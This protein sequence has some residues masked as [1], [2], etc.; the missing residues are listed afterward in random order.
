MI[1]NLDVLLTNGAVTSTTKFVLNALDENNEARLEPNQN[2]KEN[3]Y[4]DYFSW[5]MYFIWNKIK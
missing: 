2:T 4:D 3:F 5:M 1:Q